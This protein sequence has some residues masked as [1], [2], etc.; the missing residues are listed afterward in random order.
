MNLYYSRS[1]NLT[2]IFN[3]QNRIYDDSKVHI[4]KFN[5]YIIYHISIEK[6][7]LKIPKS[8]KVSSIK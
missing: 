3:K 1:D 7:I 6:S 4:F 2:I 5:N 8:D